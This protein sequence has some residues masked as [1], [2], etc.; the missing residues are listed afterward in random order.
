MMS[1]SEHE[2]FREIDEK[3]VALSK[4][5]KVLNAISWPAEAQDS[6]LASW[7][8]GNPV[9]PKVTF[10]IPDMSQLVREL[11]TLYHSIDT[12]HPIG[13]YLFKT[14][15][16]YYYTAQMLSAAGTSMLTTYSK[17]LYGDPSDELRGSQE[18]HAAAAKHFV[19]LSDQFRFDSN[20]YGAHVFYTSA[21]AKIYLET[22]ILKVIKHDEIEV[23]LDAQL[24]SKAAAGARR[25]RVRDNTIFTEYE[26]AQLLHHEV[27]THS[28][29]AING[30]AQP[31]LKSMGLA[32]PRT[33]PSQEGLA[34]FSELITGSIDL[35]RLKRISLRIMAIDMALAGADF[36]EVFKFFIGKGEPEVEAYHSSMRVFR[37]G[38]GTGGVVFTKD[39]AYLTG[40]LNVHTFFRK[41]LSENRLDEAEILFAGRMTTEDATLLFPFVREGLIA[42]PKYIPPWFRNFH[43]L[44]ANLAFSL[45]TNH[46][47]I[48]SI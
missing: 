9:I 11:E 2:Y 45:F 34:T 15:E 16:S 30:R 27:F 38:D 5:V 1:G 32:A 18:S 29:T 43:S 40:L 39:C 8:A 17:I 13:K 41:S 35:H 3:I 7:K 25:V 12:Q 21:D 23:K 20:F 31:I 14:A 37:G 26:V 6:F 24:T 44:A 47:H 46:I 22:E 33:T 19:E 48:D 28:L 36:L 4:D 10:A 42:K